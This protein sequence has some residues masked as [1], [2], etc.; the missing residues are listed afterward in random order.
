MPLN[1]C[2]D[3]TYVHVHLCKY[4]IMNSQILSKYLKFL[5]HNVSVIILQKYQQYIS[6]LH[7][8]QY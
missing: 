8:D 1:N 4:L 5:N 6:D 2:V 3:E 7:S